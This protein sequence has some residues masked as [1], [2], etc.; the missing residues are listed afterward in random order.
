MRGEERPVRR[1]L[2]ELK[3]KMKV[4]WTGAVA[5]GCRGGA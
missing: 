2:Q 4:A 3:Y 5:A 1:L